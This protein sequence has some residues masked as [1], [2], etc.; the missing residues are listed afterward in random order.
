MVCFE[1]T[2]QQR[3][4]TLHARQALDRI[5]NGGS[6]FSIE[7]PVATVVTEYCICFVFGLISL[8]SNCKAELSG[9]I[10][11]NFHHRDIFPSKVILLSWEC[12]S[13]LPSQVGRA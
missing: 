3:V 12:V 7:I 11:R 13:P 5:E 6:A 2:D 9:I 4:L 8:N 10:Q 1:K